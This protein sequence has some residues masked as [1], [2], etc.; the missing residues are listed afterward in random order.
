MISSLNIFL[1][2]A[3]FLSLDKE[4]S[5]GKDSPGHLSLPLISVRNIKMKIE[6]TE[7]S[8]IG[9]VKGQVVFRG[10]HREEEENEERE[11]L[12]TPDVVGTQA[13]SGLLG[14]LFFCCKKKVSST[15]TSERTIRLD[16][17][18]FPINTVTNAIN[19]RKYTILGFIPMVLF[20]QFKYF[21]NMFFLL[22]ALSQFIPP[23]KVGRNSSPRLTFFVRRS[24]SICVEF[25]DAEGGSRR[26]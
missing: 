12:K 10:M 25:D 8:S 26:S 23:L 5:L 24:V 13:G 2:V 9:S 20:N 15:M 7:L 1:W 21:F 19:N 14:T 17:T 4:Y 11:K 18:V 16:G 3:D 6:L 22:L